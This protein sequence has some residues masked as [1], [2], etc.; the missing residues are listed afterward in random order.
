MIFH[1]LT[2][3]IISGMSFAMM[4]MK[5]S[6]SNIIRN[7]QV[8]STQHK[9]VESIKLRINVLLASKDGYGVTLKLRKK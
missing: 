4:S 6:L 9:S 8:I 7:F 1:V 3:F 2:V 5:V